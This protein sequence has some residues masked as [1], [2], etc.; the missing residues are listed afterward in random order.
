MLLE[1]NTLPNQNYEAKK[2][3]FPLGM[4]YRK[5]HSCPN[6]CILYRNEYEDLRRSSRCGL[7]RYKVK[8]GQNDEIDE[9]TKEGPPAKVAWY[10]PTIPRLKRLFANAGDTK[11]LRW[12]ADS[13]KCDGLLPH[14]VDSLQWKNIDKE[15]PEF[16]K[17]SRNLRLGLATDRMNPFGNLS[18]NHSSWPV[19]LVI[20]NLPP[21][22]C[23]KRKY[24][25]FSMMISGPKQPGNDIDVYL[26]PLIEDLKLL[27]NEGVDVFD[28][29]KNESFRLHAMLFCTI[30]DFPAYG[31]LSGYSVKG[32]GACPI[33]QDK[34]S[35]EQLKHGRKTVYLG[36]R[37][38]LKKYHLHR[39]L[40][41]SF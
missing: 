29:F 30:N 15:F 8:V 11:N 31:N 1:G 39:R 19:L 34:T 20:Y 13:R 25:M 38:F 33:C 18:S 32:H 21:A 6:D 16:G 36:H 22:L 26:N 41:K 14:P 2:I 24:I 40:K 12:H 5:I 17:E 10:L 28:A 37:R 7:S 3:L 23:M 9:L 4:K 27:W 35:Y